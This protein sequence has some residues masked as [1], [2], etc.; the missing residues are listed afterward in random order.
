MTF[1]KNLIFIDN[2]I[3]N[4]QK[5][6]LNID[7]EKLI[8]LKKKILKKK[9]KNKIIVIG[10]GGS[11]SIASHFSVDMT[12]NA[13]IRTINFNETN[14]ISCFSNDYGFENW[15]MKSIEYY[16]EKGDILIAIS[17]SGKS[18]NI[19][20]AAKFFKKKIGLVVTFTGMSINNPLKKVGEINFHVNSSS[21]NLIENIHQFY[22]LLLV[23]LLIGKINYKSNL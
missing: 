19:I 5:Y 7:K 16:S 4:I 14:L 21:Y 23:D 9:Y 11:S 8:Y 17:S 20:K 15:I 3:K 22:L 13:K 6:I 18:K 2:Y 10:N 1:N 12:K